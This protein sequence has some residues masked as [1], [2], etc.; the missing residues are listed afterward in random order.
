M[1][2]M[3]RTHARWCSR[4]NSNALFNIKNG[5]TICLFP[6]MFCSWMSK[7][8]TQFV[9]IVYSHKSVLYFVSKFRLPNT[10]NYIPDMFLSVKC[11]NITVLFCS[12]LA[13]PDLTR[14]PDA[15]RNKYLT[16]VELTSGAHLR[17]WF[18]YKFIN[19]LG[20]Y[21]HLAIGCLGTCV[22]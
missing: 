18:G 15:Q 9:K 10:Y 4:Q 20:S 7:A 8:G 6:H 13:T 17:M 2:V 11:S 5:C 12:K 1:N 21:F 22:L 16:L 14:L 3:W 19:S